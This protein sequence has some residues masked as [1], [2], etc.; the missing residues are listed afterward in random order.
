MKTEY[1]NIALVQAVKELD[2][3]L[4]EIHIQPFEL[5]VVGGF[6]LLLH[7][8]RKDPSQFTDIDYIG[9]NLAPDIKAIICEVGNQFGLGADWINNDVL[10]SGSTLEDMELCTGKLHF[11]PAFELSTIKVNMLDKMD[12]LRMKV[13]AI[14]TSLLGCEFGGTF[15]RAKDFADVAAIADELHM[16]TAD[17]RKATRHYVMNPKATYTLIRHYMNNRDISIFYNDK[18]KTLILKPDAIDLLMMPNP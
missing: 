12:I 6:A 5:N 15:T 4:Q 1:D 2:R 9:P 14:D 16:T 3:R 18:Y 13:I 11:S 10:L 7:K 17:I 8:I